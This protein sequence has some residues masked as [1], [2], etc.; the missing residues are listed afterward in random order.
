MDFRNAAVV[1]PSSKEKSMRP[2]IGRQFQKSTLF[3]P[4]GP[5]GACTSAYVFLYCSIYRALCKNKLPSA[6]QR[7]TEIECEKFDSDYDK[8]DKSLLTNRVTSVEML[9]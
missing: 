7:R 2:L 3:P 9:Y 8:R 6:L 5:L 1:S 4:L